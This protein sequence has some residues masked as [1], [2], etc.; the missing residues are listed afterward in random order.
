VVDF[1]FG[2][3]L[4]RGVA[5]KRA[6]TS[7]DKAGQTDKARQFLEEMPLTDSD[8]AAASVRFGLSRAPKRIVSP[9][10]SPKSL[11]NY[12]YS[13]CGPMG[14]KHY[15]YGLFYSTLLLLIFKWSDTAKR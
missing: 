6:Y 12:E 8:S 10:G 1:C 5:D 9:L 13:Y 14:H 11:L 7:T 15:A 4:G 2:G 3:L